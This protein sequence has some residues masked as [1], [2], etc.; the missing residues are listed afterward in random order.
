M[1]ARNQE[2]ADFIEA[3]LDKKGITSISR[4]EAFLPWEHIRKY[5]ILHRVVLRSRVFDVN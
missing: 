4:K 2:S 1:A 3:G 5:D